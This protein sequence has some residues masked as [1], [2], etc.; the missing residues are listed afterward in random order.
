M[1]RVAVIDLG[2]NTF[3]LLIAEA[4]AETLLVLHKEKI[5]VKIGEGGITQGM[6]TEAAESRALEAL[7]RFNETMR[8]YQPAVIRATA[9]SAFRNA[10][11]ATQVMSKIKKLIGIDLEIISGDQEAQFIY[12]GV[13]Q[14]VSLG[15]QR[16]LIVD[17][18]GGS[19][20][21][22]IA[23]NNKIHWKKS[24]EIGAQRLMDLFHHHDPILK[25]E[26]ERLQ[27]FLREKLTT[28][29]QAINKFRPT[30]LVG[31]SGTFDTLSDIYLK[32]NRMAQTESPEKPLTV[33][34]FRKI[35]ENILT[36]NKSQRLEIPGMLEMR[37]DM[38]VVACCLI[39]YLLDN[40]NLDTI[41]VSSYALKEGL[42][43][44]VV[45][46]LRESGLT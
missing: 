12:L 7:S 44:Q 29:A 14:A 18:G 39:G 46:D 17:I 13:A 38:I 19:V 28:L 34:G 1:K 32:E 31:S 16:A 5:S 25:Q 45:N 2:T 3:H 4:T 35:L 27:E 21:F 43:K 20:E 41:R 40:F 42:L 37:V 26:I 6:I 22:I 23:D 30:E 11:N 24:F 9:T 10:A 15:D 33:A 8:S 36:M